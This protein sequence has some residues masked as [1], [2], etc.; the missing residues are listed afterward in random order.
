MKSALKS[1]LKTAALPLRRVAA[2]QLSAWAGAALALLLLGAAGTLESPESPLAASASTAAGQWLLAVL[3]GLSALGPA[4]AIGAALWAV[5]L[6]SAALLR[7]RRQSIRWREVER[8]ERAMFVAR[9]RRRAP[10]V[11]KQRARS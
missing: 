9:R 2:G 1:D 7:R 4:A 8:M 3:I 10:E 11:T 6:G 5:V